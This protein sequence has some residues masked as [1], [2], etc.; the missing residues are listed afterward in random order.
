[1]AEIREDK[2]QFFNIMVCGAAGVGKS[3]FIELFMLKF[4]ETTEGDQK[5]VPPLPKQAINP[6]TDEF[7][8]HCINSSNFKL[9][10]V[11]GPGYGNK[12]DISHW[13]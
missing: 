13:R 8:N 2:V 11:D 4:H 3:S 10:V 5:V 12:T 6:P 7:L 9:N 1:M